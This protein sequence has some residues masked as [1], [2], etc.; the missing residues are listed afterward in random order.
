M[1]VYGD[2]ERIKRGLVQLA[3]NAIKASPPAT[4][5]VLRWMSEG[6]GATRI[7]VLDRG[8][9]IPA[10]ILAGLG[11]AFLKGNASHA[12]ALPGAGPGLALATRMASAHGGRL[13]TEARQDGGSQA[14]LILPPHQIP[15]DE[16]AQFDAHA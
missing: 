13:S 10:E 7:E 12:R 8:P 4:T 11:T 1:P 16:T 6:P 2:I 14:A 15:A 3:D 9:C 5:V